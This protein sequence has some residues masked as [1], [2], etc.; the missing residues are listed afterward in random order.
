MMSYHSKQTQFLNVQSTGITAP[1]GTLVAKVTLLQPQQAHFLQP[2]NPD[3]KTDYLNPSVNELI[4]SSNSFEMISHPRTVSGLPHRKR[5]K[6]LKSWMELQNEFTTNFVNL[7]IKK[8]LIQRKIPKLKANFLASLTGTN[9][10]YHNSK[11]RNG[12]TFDRIP[13]MTYFHD[14]DGNKDFKFKLTPEHHKPMYTQ[15]PPTPIHLGEDLLVQ[16]ALMQYYGRVTTL[17]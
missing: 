16:L 4:A 17:P 3:W 7:R 6:S 11:N 9:P 10:F 1:K 15:G 2:V 5:A 12:Q 14:I 13:S 8:T